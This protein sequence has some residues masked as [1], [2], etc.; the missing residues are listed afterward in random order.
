[1]NMDVHFLQHLR[2]EDNVG[3]IM[4]FLPLKAHVTGF[5]SIITCTT[6]DSAAKP[7][8]KTS[9]QPTRFLQSC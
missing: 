4:G 3:K 2:E 9:L 1:M 7:Q 6:S 8:V 5:A